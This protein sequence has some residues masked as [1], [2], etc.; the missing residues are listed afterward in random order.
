MERIMRTANIIETDILVIGGGIAACLAAIEAK[1]ADVDVV[2][3]DKAHVGRSGNSPLMSGI[4]TMFDPNEDDYGDWLGNCVEVG[5]YLNE[6]DILGQVIQETTN[7]IQELQSWGVKFRKKNGKIERYRSFAGAMNTKMACG[8]IQLMNV[9]RGEAIR[10]GVHAVNRVMIVYLLTSDGELP[11]RGRVVGALGFDIRNGKPHVFSAKGTIICSGGVALHRSRGISPFVLGGDGIMAAFRAGCQL[12]NLELTLTGISPA[13][14]NVAPG[15]HL[16]LGQGGH[17]LNAAGERFMGRYDPLRME[18]APRTKVGIAV[19]KE[20]LEGRGPVF[21]DL[22]HLDGKAHAAIKEG[23]PI[24]AK[25]MEKAG[26]DLTRDLVRYKNS[27]MPCMGAGGIRIN[28]ERASTLLGLYAAGSTA[29][30]AEDG[31]DNVIGAGMNSAVAG[32]IAGRY[33]TRDAS[34]AE[35]SLLIENQVQLLAEEMFRPL[36]RHKGILYHVIS[37]EITE[38][39]ESILAVRSENALNV[40]LQR[41]EQIES[42]KIS[43]LQA[44]DYHT[45]AGTLGVINKLSFLKLFCNVALMRTESRGGHYRLD[46]PERD[47]RNWLKWVICQ[48]MSQGIQFWTEPVPFEKYPLRPP[49]KDRVDAY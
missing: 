10:R 1:N 30:H 45:L 2:L 37:K 43:K 38:I 15:A 47:D 5:Q 17:L 3:V 35:P 39:W 33:A 22:R 41:T 49:I 36:K 12:K 42:E 31:A 32:K 27:C 21:Q 23:V 14:F 40:A 28:K 20:Y 16:M 26:L 6:Q 34:E 13:D 18:L 24:Y 4:L 7:V 11:T 19:E 44:V 9:V 48:Q 25:I 29:D 46:Y 8:A